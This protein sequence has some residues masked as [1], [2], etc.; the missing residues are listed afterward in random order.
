MNSIFSTIDYLKTHAVG[1]R[2]LDIGD[3]K[4]EETVKKKVTG[5]SSIQMELNFANFQ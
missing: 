5:E 3:L 2:V 1:S 4:Q